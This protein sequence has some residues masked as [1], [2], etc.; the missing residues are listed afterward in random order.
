MQLRFWCYI[1]HHWY[2]STCTNVWCLYHLY[3][4]HVHIIKLSFLFQNTTTTM[5][6]YIIGLLVLWCCLDVSEGCNEALCVS[7]VSKC[8]LI[9]SCDCDMTDIRN[10]SCCKDCNMCLSTLYT[11]CCS[12]VGKFSFY[13]HCTDIM[14]LIC[15]KF[16]FYKH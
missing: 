11:E 5:R 12:C 15:D 14:W 1:I 9:K 10:C 3:K 8:M 13:K 7:I 4:N 16:S 2:I 6:L